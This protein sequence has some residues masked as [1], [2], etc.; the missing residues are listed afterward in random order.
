VGD[1]A[2]KAITIEIGKSRITATA[3]TDMELL[4]KVCRSLMSIC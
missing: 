1:E 4:T 2:E 3:D